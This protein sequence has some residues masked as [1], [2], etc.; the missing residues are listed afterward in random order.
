MLGWDDLR[1]FLAVARHG[2]HASAGR[3]LGVAATTVGRRLAE[4]EAALGARLFLR[5]PTGLQP[6]DAGVRLRARAE[7]V[8]SE[9]LACERELAGG[10]ARV[11]GRVRLTAGDGIATRVLVPALRP[12]LEAHPGLE[13]EVRADNR[14]LDLSRREADV[15]LRLS[16]PRE[17]ALVARRL[18]DV[19]YGVYAGG[20]YLAR[21]P[22]GRRG[23]GR[24]ELAAHAWLDYDPGQE[25]SPPSR[26]LRK[27]VP[28]ARVALR[29]STTLALLAACASGQ[30]L[31]VLPEAVAAGDPR[32][33][34]LP[35]RVVLPTAPLWALTHE[36]LRRSARV[37]AVLDWLAGLF[38]TRPPGGT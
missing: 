6:S 37:A 28:G 3:A 38:P 8:E 36:D 31:A 16:R 7:R 23:A 25:A 29:A 17:G 5:T 14:S 34:P 24:R 12:L 33:V 35:T 21:H 13:V 4:L 27:A 18:S 19:A 9:V 20:D 1:F 32:L 22:A 30:G 15:A 2:S 10:D 26:W 11:H